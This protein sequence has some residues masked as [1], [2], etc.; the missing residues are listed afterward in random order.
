MG[1]FWMEVIAFFSRYSYI[2]EQVW[3][4][5]VVVLGVLFLLVSMSIVVWG[6]VFVKWIWFRRLRKRMEIFEKQFWECR[7]LNELSQKAKGMKDS[8][9]K[10]VFQQGYDEL[11]RINRSFQDTSRTS[12]LL[13][14]ERSLY[15]AKIY[16]KRLLDR[17]LSSLAIVAA[18][19][20]FIGLFGTVWG[21]M[22]SFQEIARSGDSSLT[23]VAPGISEA[24]IATAVGLG[25]A[26]PAVVAY[27]V[28]QRQLKS[29]LVLVD[30]FSLDFL[31]IVQR[32]FYKMNK[33]RSTKLTEKTKDIESSTGFHKDT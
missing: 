25:T 21:I 3:Q 28:L 11:Y 15:K 5:G 27:N 1:Q 26:I 6:I 24:L 29:L 8:P 10:E 31:N 20:P 23:A 16:E 22:N 4:G 19:A 12:V 18:T 32:Y 9:L 7:S 30:G 33:S 2:F 14:I 13:N 17:Y